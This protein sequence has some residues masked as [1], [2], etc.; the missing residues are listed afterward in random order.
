MK[1]SIIWQLTI[2]ILF[3]PPSYVR[4]LLALTRIKSGKPAKNA[5]CFAPSATLRTS[6]AD[7]TETTL[8]DNPEFQVDVVRDKGQGSME[9]I[10]N[11]PNPEIFAN[12]RRAWRRASSDECGQ[13][14][15]EIRNFEVI[16]QNH[17]SGYT[18]VWL[19]S[20]RKKL[21]NYANDAD[22]MKKLVKVRRVKV[23]PAL[24][25]HTLSSDAA[26][27]RADANAVDSEL[28]Q[29]RTELARL[30]GRSFQQAKLERP[31]FVAVPDNTERL[32]AFSADAIK[33]RNVI[34]TVSR[35]RSAV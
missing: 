32:L 23:K 1:K 35:R 16:K 5:T 34:K 6:L 3:S 29:V 25:R 24:R 8:L 19:L 18:Q 2:V 26:K 12:I 10:W 13:H 14:G 31:A 28:R 17:C 7:A 9:Q 4:K 11:L 21:W 30:T 15:A 33:P 22:K 27:L 20:E